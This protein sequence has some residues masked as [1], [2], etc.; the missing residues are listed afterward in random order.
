MR[1]NGLFDH[2]RCPVIRP[3]RCRQGLSSTESI[4]KAQLITIGISS[5][6][7]VTLQCIPRLMVDTILLF[8]IA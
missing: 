6:V 3:G 5:S 1:G 7:F 4:L 8:R 2:Q